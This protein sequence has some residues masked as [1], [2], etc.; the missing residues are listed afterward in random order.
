MTFRINQH[1]FSGS[2]RVFDRQIGLAAILRSMAVD[3]AIIRLAADEP[4]GLTDNS[5]GTATLGYAAFPKT[6]SA[7]DA[8]AGGGVQNTGFN[9]ALGSVRNAH[10]VIA[11]NIAGIRAAL[12]L[13]ALT[14]AEGTVATA[15]TV[16]AVTKTATAGQ[17]TAAVSFASFRAS[18]AA[19]AANQGVLAKAVAE[20]RAAVGLD[21][22]M[23]VLDWGGEPN[24]VLA[25][26]PATA[27]NAAAG[28]PSVALA[29]GTAVL[30]AA[31]NNIATFADLLDD[32]ITKI[33]ETN[34]LSVV[35]AD[36]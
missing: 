29:D 3:N 19:L 22:S 26:I 7:F 24:Y 32:V 33:G 25:A 10:A 4:E 6:F 20:I 9:T 18:V 31:A 21:T 1:Y 34:P 2:G 14:V 23:G 16:A 5:T 11:A 13:P 8:S 15:D 35:A 12:G 30:T 27:A 36:V 28:D 17:G